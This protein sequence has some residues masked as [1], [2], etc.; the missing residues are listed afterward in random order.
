MLRKRM[1]FLGLLLVALVAI[2]FFIVR[3]DQLPLGVMDQSFA[4]ASP[5][6]SK[7]DPLVQTSPSSIAEAD[8]YL[9]D[10]GLGIVVSIGATS[11]FYPYQILA[12]HQ[13]VQESIVG[14]D[15]LIT[16]SPLTDTPRVFS[17]RIGGQTPTFFV[18]ETIINNN[19]VIQDDQNRAWQQLTGIGQGGG[20][21]ESLPS[22]LMTWREFKKQH[23]QGDVLSKP[24]DG[25][26]DY[27]H[28]PYVSYR[29][30]RD[31]LY[32]LSHKDLRL[33]AKQRIWGTLISG[34][35]VAYT[36]KPEN[37]P[38]AIQSYWFAWSA[39]YPS[40]TIAP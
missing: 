16:Y 24:N 27:T 20:V 31:V 23:P 13:L 6:I 11:R 18:G 15:L 22:D 36:Q 25:S 32:P 8:Q 10:D 14:R 9:N 2:S 21:L 34:A 38:L 7:R 28:D 1:F 30:N 35:P 29:D 19:L 33:P 5:W 39:F 37:N 12:W 40:T 4:E 3:R 17:A 26:S